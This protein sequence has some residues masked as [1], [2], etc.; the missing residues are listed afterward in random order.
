M[1]CVH[2]TSDR[3]IA[4]LLCGALESHGIAA[5]VDG[6][7]LSP[8]QGAAIPAGTAAEF[9]VCI[10]DAEQ[11]PQAQRFVRDWLERHAAATPAGTWVCSGCGE[12]HEA[13]F[14]SCWRCGAEEGAASR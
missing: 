6:E 10:A 7:H 2:R 12:T 9:R 11:L 3:S 1:S 14:S 4:Q 8:L 5:R 13:Q